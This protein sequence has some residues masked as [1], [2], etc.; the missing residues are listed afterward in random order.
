[1]LHKLSKYKHLVLSLIIICFGTAI[2]SCE[3]LHYIARKSEELKK[4]MK[5]ETAQLEGVI[6]PATQVVIREKFAL[7]EEYHLPCL[8]EHI[9]T[10]LVRTGFNKLTEE[11]LRSQY[12]EEDGWRVIWQKDKVILQLN[13]EGLCPEH[14]KQWHL[15]SDA[16]GKKVAVYAGPAEVGRGCGDPAKVTEIYL[17]KLPANLQQKIRAGSWEFLSW[18]ELIATLDSLGEYM[19]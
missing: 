3:Y 17:D 16:S 11:K 18:E 5:T 13:Q 9:P 15:L 10:G 2:T 7:C 19:K 14:S 6:T 12:A 8:W 4:T 1:M